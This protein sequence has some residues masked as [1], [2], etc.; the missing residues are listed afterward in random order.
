MKF[1]ETCSKCGGRME[2]GFVLDQTYGACL[3]SKWIEGRPIK[4]FL[5]GIKIRGRT[6]REIQSFRCTICG[7][8]ESYA[9][10]S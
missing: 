8:L 4:A 1:P 6:A 3:T 10:D 2:E 5:T 9:P 7:F